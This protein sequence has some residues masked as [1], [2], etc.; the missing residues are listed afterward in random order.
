MIG[1]NRN[2]DLNQYALELRGSKLF[3]EIVA[4]LGVS[5]EHARCRNERGLKK[6]LSVGAKI[7]KD[8]LI[9]GRLRVE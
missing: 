2:T 6:H 9:S 3:R 1:N 8:L 5:L 7:M 4:E